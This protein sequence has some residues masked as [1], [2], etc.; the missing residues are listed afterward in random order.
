VL[1]LELEPPDDELL[2]DEP[3]Y[4][5]LA[6]PAGLRVPEGVYPGPHAASPSVASMTMRVLCTRMD[7]TKS[8]SVAAL[9]AEEGAA[10]DSPGRHRNGRA[11]SA[12]RGTGLEI[13]GIAGVSRVWKPGS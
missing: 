11:S 4:E 6:G 12:L 5:L 3:L 10:R 9:R 8:P 13:P 7:M 1:V 2:D